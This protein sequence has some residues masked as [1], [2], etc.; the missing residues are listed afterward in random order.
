MPANVRRSDTAQRTIA[1]DLRRVGEEV[2]R[3]RVTHG[4]SQSAVA[5]AARCSQSAVHRVERAT[6]SGPIGTWARICQAVGLGLRASVFPAG[7]AVRDT[8][9]LALLE[10]LQALIAPSIVWRTEV[11]LPR[12]GDP[13]SWDAF[14]RVGPGRIGVEAE[15]RPTDAQEL[16]RRTMAKKRDGGVDCVILLLR[17]TRHVRRLLREH[18]ELIGTSFSLDSDAALA[19]L[20]DGRMPARDPIILLPS[21]RATTMAARQARA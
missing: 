2:R 9:H 10:D 6:F 20:A 7:D 3:A 4:L 21:R 18:G 16:T 12:P 19:A 1:D 14:L 5:R 11:P 13:R 8:A 15:T 17:D